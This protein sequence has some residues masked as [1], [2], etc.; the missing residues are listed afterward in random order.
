M[1]KIIVFLMLIS[2]NL[3][4]QDKIDPNPL[5]A[6]DT[7]MSIRANGSNSFLRC[8]NWGSQGKAL[9]SALKMNSSHDF[10]LDST[11]TNNA[12]NMQVI[13]AFRDYPFHGIDNDLVFNGMSLFLS[14][15]IIP[16]STPNFKAKYGDKNGSVFGF[17]YR[18]LSVGY[19]TSKV[20]RYTLHKAG[21][22]DSVKVLDSIWD[23]TILRY[24]NPDYSIEL[25]G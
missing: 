15:Y 8:W 22:T 21:I 7:A 3:F 5:L 12:S 9:D 19:D 17:N 2:F 23:G 24:L 14:P 25:N 4:S 10:D 16:D 6:I 20:N 11:T 13:A 1:K 18:N